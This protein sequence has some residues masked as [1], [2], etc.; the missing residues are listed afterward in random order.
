MN[1]RI[2]LATLLGALSLGAAAQGEPRPAR[3]GDV[4]IYSGE[5][6]TDKQRFEETV[7]ILGVEAGQVRTRHQRSDRPSPTEGLYTR[8]WGTVRSGNTGSHYE[9]AA[10]PVKQPLE[11][12]RTWEEVYQ[13]K[14]ATGALFRIKMESTVVA[15]E[16]L[17]TA[18]GEFDTFRIEAKA[19]LS[20]LSF[21]GGFGIAQKTW[22]APA[23]DRVVRYEYKEQ[24][25]LGADNVSELKAFKPAD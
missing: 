5:A 21:Q 16:K 25:T 6:R 20:G 1:S 4:A 7:T 14:S 23:I 11:V 15:R 2:A 8:D 3:A 13:G 18:A 22:Y 9:P 10:S 17:T 24:R 19:Y 12:G